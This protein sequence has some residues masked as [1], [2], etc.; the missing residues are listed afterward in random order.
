MKKI[1]V[2]EDEHR[3][4]EDIRMILELEGYHAD[5]AENGLAGLNKIEAQQPDLI[6]CDIIMPEMD[7]LTLLR[8]LRQHPKF[9]PIPFVL[10]SARTSKE[11]IQAGLAAGANAYITKP[12]TSDVL[13]NTIEEHVS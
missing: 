3:I 6:V 11:D 2:I 9:H 10:L 4:S 7:G 1:L 13:V 5:V 12:Y 8:R